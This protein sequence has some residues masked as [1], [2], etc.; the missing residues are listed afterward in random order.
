MESLYFDHFGQ[1][2]YYPAE[3]MMSDNFP[4]PDLVKAEIRREIE[5]EQQAVNSKKRVKQWVKRLSM[6]ERNLNDL[7]NCVH[8][9]KAEIRAI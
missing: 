9:L 3:V 8:A 6:I 4:D 2:M 7:L 5:S 1:P